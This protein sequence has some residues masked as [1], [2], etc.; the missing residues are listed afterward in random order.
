M[1]PRDPTI[2][3]LRRGV[4]QFRV[5]ALLREGER[6]SFDLVRALADSLLAQGATALRE[7]RQALRRRAVARSSALP[8]LVVRSGR[9]RPPDPA[10]VPSYPG[11]TFC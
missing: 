11:I 4:L 9:P 6:Y 7:L 1:T 10:W 5:L 3:Q 2:S 8:S